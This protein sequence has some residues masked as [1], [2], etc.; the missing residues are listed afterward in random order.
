MRFWR[1]SPVDPIGAWAFIISM[2]LG[3]N[4]TFAED[5]PANAPPSPRSEAADVNELLLQLDINSQ[6]LDETVLV[7]KSRSGELYA[8]AEDLKRWR[9]RLPEEPPL[10][11][12]DGLFYRLKAIGGLE[13]V[14]DEGHLTVSITAPAQ[15]FVATSLDDSKKQ[16]PRA[17]RS[18]LGGFVNYDLLAERAAGQVHNSGLFELGAFNGLG[19]GVGSFVLNEADSTRLTRLETTWTTDLPDRLTSVRFGDSIS[20]A[21]MWGRS[22]RFGGIQYG[23]NFAV[24]PGLVTLPMQSVGGLAALPSTVDVYVNNNLA[25][26]T[27]VNPGPFSIANV[28]V[29]TG[30]GDV[31]VVVRDL[32]GRE[33]VITQPFY[34]SASLLTK[35][36][37]DFSYELGFVRENF[38]ATSED[39]GRGFLGATHRLGITEDFTGEVRA[40][41]QI[42]RQTLGLG[43]ALLLRSFGILSDAIAFSRG[44]SGAGGLVSVGLERQ[45]GELSF[46]IHTQIASERFTQ[47]GLDPRKPAPRRLTS[48]NVG[49]PVPGCFGSM[50]LA[51]VFLDNRDGKPNE[52]ASAAWN[53][54]LGQFGYLSLDVSRSLHQADGTVIG[55]N[56]TLPLGQRTATSV[57]MTTQHG[58]NEALAEV[59]QSLP[60]GP[61]FGYLIQQGNQGTRNITLS[62][63]T[64]SGTYSV[65]DAAS[66]GE[67]GIRLGA[68][69]G[70]ALLDGVHLS[71][72]ITDSFGLVEVPD[73]PNV[74]I[75]A[76]N[77]LMGQTDDKGEVLLPR[78]RAYEKNVISIEQ[79]D[80][81]LD[82]KV[83]SLSLDAVP[84]FRSG[85]VLKFPITRAHDA[86]LSITLDDG[87]P[88]PA[89]ALVKIAGQDEDF[90]VGHEG[91]VYLTGLTARNRLQATWRDQSCELTV[92]FPAKADPLPN[93]GT[94]VCT[95][96]RP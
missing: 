64:N 63:Q 79:M 25:S 45:A 34:A 91:L 30:Q 40:E 15:D 2:L 32:L 19:V 20:Q 42:D 88:L 43:S 56:W 4:V 27:E 44:P 52:L 8:D 61:G 75:Y 5:H 33:Q 3:L 41:L 37:H 94:F 36:L 28:P 53:F 83:G 46:G 87:T 62:A 47:L 23:T 12:K 85:T 9:L 7:L 35:G 59:Q 14:L 29:V 67:N 78:L 10:K 21:G 86:L 71:R 84:Y 74:R 55:A 22:V 54:Q 26:R 17:T 65:T 16:R 70:V 1:R 6:G 96:V 31:R 73:F 69:G 58:R 72:R 82:A 50:G 38:G 49:L 68:S 81:P 92:P 80:L 95:G 90:P 13:Y 51:Y 24:Q 77:Q 57:D 66:Q 11:H 48:L 76:D 89:G 39:Y 93:L 18:S 60:S